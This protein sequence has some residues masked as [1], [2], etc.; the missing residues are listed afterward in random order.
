MRPVR[1]PP[2]V[3]ALACLGAAAAE[4]EAPLGPRPALG[5]AV[6]LPPAATAAEQNRALAEARRTGVSLFALPVSWSAGEPAP[7]HY[8]IADVTRTARL[9][10][11]SGAVLHLDLPLVAGRARDVPRDLAAVPFDDSRLSLR[12]GRFLD[13]LSPALLDF[14]TVSLG[15]QADTYFMDKPEEL[16]AFCRLFDGAVQFLQKRAPHLRAGVTTSAPNESPAAAVAAALHQRSPVLFYV[17]A[18]FERARPFTHR[19]PDAIERDWKQLLHGAG[20]RP[21]AFP[22]VSF[23]SAEENGSSPAKQAEFVRRLRKFLASA[24]GRRLLFA[25]YVPWRDPR[26]DE[27]PAGAGAL[28][29]AFARQAFLANRGLQTAAGAAKPAWREWVRA[30]EAARPRGR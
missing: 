6:N 30:A 16:H 9:L 8:R 2:L 5:L 21:V 13:T 29:V 23:S 19:S 10:R 18:P 14:A 4:K 17:Y 1:R 7:G 12:L 25:R 20:G 24:D 15:Y 26:E 28:A 27:V 3:L 22:E 11:Q